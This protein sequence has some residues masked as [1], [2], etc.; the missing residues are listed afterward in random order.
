VEDQSIRVE[1]PTALL[2]FFL[3]LRLQGYEAKV[4]DSGDGSWEV[5]VQAGAPRDWV[6]SCVQRWLDDEA[7]SAVAVQIGTESYTMRPSPR[8]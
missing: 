4:V 5:E 3:T 8:A 2:G 6:L 1:A 7:L